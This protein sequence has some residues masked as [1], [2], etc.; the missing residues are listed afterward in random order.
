MHLLICKG[1]AADVDQNLPLLPTKFISK[2][3]MVIFAIYVSWQ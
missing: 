2:R 1:A 3:N